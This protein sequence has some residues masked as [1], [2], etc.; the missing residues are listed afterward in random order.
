MTTSIEVKNKLGFVDGSIPKPEDDDPYCKIWRHCNSMVKLWLLNSVSKK[1]YTSI[2]YFPTAAGIWKD[3]HTRFHKSSLP[4]LYKLRQQ[5]HSL[6]QG[7]L[8]LSSYHTQTQI[9]WEELAS[10][11]V[12]PRTVED[13]LSERETNRVIDF[14]MG[15]NDCY[16]AV[17]SQILMK[18]TLPSL[19]EVYNMIDQDETQRSARISTAPG[20][21]SSAFVVSHQS[22]QN[23]STGG[24]QFQMKERPV[25]T[26]CSRVGHVEDTCYKKHGY[27]TSFKS[28]QK[29]VKPP[30]SVLANVAVGSM[31]EDSPM[32]NATGSNDLT[33]SQIQQ[34][35]SFLSSKLQ[36]PS[37]PAQPE[38]HSVSVSSDPS[39]SSTV[40]PISGN[41][42]PSIICS[43]AGIDRPYVC[44]LDSN[45]TAIQTWVID[46]GATNHICHDKHSF[47]SFHYLQNTTVSLPNRIRVSIV[48]IGSV[49]LG[50]HLIL[51]DVLFIPQFKF[52]LFS[53]SSLTKSMGCRIWFDQTS[54]VLQD[55]T[56]ELMVGMGKQI[57]NLYILDLESLSHPGKES[58]FI[59]ASVTSH[60]LWHKR[61]GHPSVQKLQPMSSLLSFPKQKNVTDFP[62]KSVIYQNKN[63]FL[64]SLI[65]IEVQDLL[66]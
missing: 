6:R 5:I 21:D 35:V 8:D 55:P 53:V 50:R 43:F 39:S 46:T 29:F 22:S 66:I 49:H 25:C 44:S 47:S 13:L 37:T 63:I 14:L 18:K 10:L 64:L 12:V 1:I 52:N 3:L 4:R 30:S 40:C 32:P 41:F 56:R 48:G 62:I 51:H 19:S 33:T 34:L 27:P 45:I 54:C 28:K 2:L 15:L 31:S 42:Y 24:T 38:V 26:Y 61:L 16:D 36:P 23:G 7:T 9:L 17:R 65:I 57:A 20:M 60:D 58:S 59:V 11:Q